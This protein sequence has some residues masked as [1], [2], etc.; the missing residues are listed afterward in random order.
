MIR[1]GSY[2]ASALL[3][4][5]ASMALVACGSTGPIGA[6]W[7]GTTRGEIR[8]VDDMGRRLPFTTAHR[9]RWSSA[10]DGTSY[11]ACT[12]IGN[13]ELR[14]LGFDAAS[15]RDAAGTDGQTIRGCAWISNDRAWQ[16]S[17]VVGNSD[18]L[19]ED[20][21]RNSTAADTWLADV[22]IDGR[23]VGVHH[24]TTG[25][26]CDTYVQ[27]EKA[28]AYTLVTHS[29][30]PHPSIEEICAKA[31]EFTEATIGKMPP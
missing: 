23:L 15:V 26:S 5:G 14:S 25:W 17:Q 20:R 8:Q 10:N 9:N 18:S 6:K 28:G 1:A 29:M 3:L 12:A 2:T 16:I 30:R 13:S 19:A 21:A 31:L 11:E 24:D 22:P 7:S 4:L 27:V